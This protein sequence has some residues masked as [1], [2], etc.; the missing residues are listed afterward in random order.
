MVTASARLLMGRTIVRVEISAHRDQIGRLYH[1]PV[2]TLD[3]GAVLTFTTEE[4][5]SGAYGVC[6]N[7]HPPRKS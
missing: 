6:P 1:D 3:N 5:N 2:F 4:T 7:Y